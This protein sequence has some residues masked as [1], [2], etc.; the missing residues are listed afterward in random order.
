MDRDISMKTTCH[1]DRANEGNKIIIY[2]KYGFVDY[3]NIGLKSVN[4]LLTGDQE[5][6]MVT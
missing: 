3:S 5:V 2:Y 1:M 4:D 6:H